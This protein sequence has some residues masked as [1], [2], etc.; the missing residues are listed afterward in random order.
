MLT[1]TSAGTSSA[2]LTFDNGASLGE[3]SDV[4]G[5]HSVHCGHALEINDESGLFGRQRQSA[6]VF[7]TPHVGRTELSR[8]DNAHRARVLDCADAGH[9]QRRLSKIRAFLGFCCRDTIGAFSRA[10][11]RER[12]EALAI[13]RGKHITWL[14]V[15]MSVN[16]CVCRDGRAEGQRVRGHQ[17][18]HPPVDTK[19]PGVADHALAKVRG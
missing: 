2:L 12:G 3:V 1:D 6:G 13:G 9:D 8:H 11:S 14:C 4:G 5:G 17:S 10:G 19:S 18:K 16:P 7:E 15:G